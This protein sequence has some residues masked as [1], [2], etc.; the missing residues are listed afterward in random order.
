VLKTKKKILVT[1]ACG[2]LGA[3]LTLAL[4][5]RYGNDGLLTPG[6]TKG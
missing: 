5:E 6:L 1:G 2:Q 3:E 4:R